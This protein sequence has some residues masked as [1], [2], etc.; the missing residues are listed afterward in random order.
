MIEKDDIPFEI[1]T[2]RQAE[3]LMK[4]LALLKALLEI[5][6]GA[7]LVDDERVWYLETHLRIFYLHC[8]KTGQLL[9]SAPVA[10]SNA[11]KAADPHGLLTQEARLIIQEARE[12]EGQDP[13]LT[14]PS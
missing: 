5:E 8:E 10:Y 13:S 2:S 9:E 11:W 1:E 14:E 6:G 3:H 12:A 4:E 7:D